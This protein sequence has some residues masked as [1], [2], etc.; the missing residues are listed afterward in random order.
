V[1]TTNGGL[2]KED[3]Q[4]T[5]AGTRCGMNFALVITW[6]DL[7]TP[8]CRTVNIIRNFERSFW[9]FIPL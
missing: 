3:K 4:N 8:K 2:Q 5:K 7:L 9:I 6:N 1:N